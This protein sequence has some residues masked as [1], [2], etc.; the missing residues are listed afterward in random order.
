M[1][2][3]EAA[4]LKTDLAAWLREYTAMFAKGFHENNPALLRPY[5]HVPALRLGRTGVVVTNSLEEHDALWAAA[6]EGLRPLGYHDSELVT[7]DVNLTSPA[8]AFLT[9]EAVRTKA[10]GTELQRFFSSYLAAKT[11]DGW[12][13][14]AWV[15]HW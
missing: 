15:G 4:D 8:S 1:D 2:D 11:E 12:K 9:A 13:I 3:K 7:V 10:D 6:Y 14:T 5:C